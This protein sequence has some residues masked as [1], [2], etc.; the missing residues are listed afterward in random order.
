MT[1]RAITS[2]TKS[3]STTKKEDKPIVEIT[4]TCC[5]ETKHDTEFYS[6]QSE[7]FKANNKMCICKNCVIEIFDFYKAKYKDDEQA[8]IYRT[9]ELL[10]VYYTEN[11]IESSRKEMLKRGSETGSVMKFYMKNVGMNQY[12]NMSFEDREITHIH[13]KEIL[14]EKELAELTETKKEKKAKEDCMKL[15]GY[16]AFSSEP[17]KEK[18][19]LYS[20]LVG[21]LDSSTLKDNFKIPIVIQIVKMFNQADQLDR[22]LSEHLSNPDVILKSSDDINRIIGAKQ[23]IT[24]AVLSMAKDN[25][26]SVN[27]SNNKSKG[28][29]TLTG[30]IKELQEIGFEDAD[31]NLFD[32]ETLGGIKHVADESNKSIAEQL[33]FDEND[34][35]EMISEQKILIEKFQKSSDKMEEENRKIKTILNL[36]GLKY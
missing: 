12:K 8:S 2:K 20:K 23:K 28:A 25:G 32:V 34:Y 30:I 22:A 9:C 31:V 4:C 3:K 1:T 19:A 14:Y 27:Y 17:V 26:I 10:D 29:G 7:I 13:A 35:T 36:N 18:K 33:Q 6:S 16:D 24:S 21:F 5:G 11:L 15:I